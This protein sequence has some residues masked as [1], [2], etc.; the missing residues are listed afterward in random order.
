[1]LNYSC[2]PT[3]RERDT[4]PLSSSELELVCLCLQKR[5]PGAPCVTV[6]LT[7]QRMISREEA[8]TGLPR[9]WLNRLPVCCVEEQRLTLSAVLIYSTLITIKDSLK[10][11]DHPND[12]GGMFHIYFSRTET[13]RSFQK[14]RNCHFI[15]T[16][17]S[18]YQSN[19]LQ[20]NPGQTFSGTRTE[21][22]PLNQQIWAVLEYF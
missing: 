20:V 2:S 17:N 1:M 7:L 22:T 10:S 13:F 14:P 19:Y 16:L 18:R 5:S 21:L 9:E 6:P 15:C 3:T 12:F 11:Q 4:F 8:C